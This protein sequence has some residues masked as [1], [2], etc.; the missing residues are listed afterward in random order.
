[1]N[2]TIVPI[3][4]TYKS[5]KDTERNLVAGEHEVRIKMYQ[6]RSRTYMGT[7]FSSSLENWNSKTG[8]PESTHPKFKALTARIN[9]LTE[10]ISFEIK[11][12]EKVGRIITPIEIKVM[13]TNRFKT[14]TP[15]DKPNKILAYIQH[16]IDYYNEVENPGYAGVF[17]ANKL[18]VKK[19]LKNNDKMFLAFT[20]ADHEALEKQLTGLSESTKSLYLR[21][22]YRVWNLAIADGFC[23]KD[24]HPR[25][26]IKFKPYKKIRTKKRSIKLDYWKRILKLKPA[27]DTR[28]YRSHLLMQFMYYSR[29]MN[30]NDMLKLKKEQF[31]NE[32][33]HYKRS[34]NKRSYDFQL[35][36]KAVKIIKAFEEYAEQSDAGYIFPFIYKE[37]DTALKI[38]ARIDSALKDLNED[39]KAMAEVVG[40][41]KQFTSNA[42]R[43]GFASHLNEANV[44]IKIIQEALGHETQAQTRVYL[45]D[46]DDSIIAS[47]INAALVA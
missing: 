27:K 32:G 15:V 42:L 28:I 5:V 6:N 7:G 26:H 2:I 1:M 34:K 41:K 3:L 17:Y 21:T 18:V 47:A 45:D 14:S 44:D 12:A 23:T 4:W 36:P 16:L 35:H 30:F 9:K 20:K 46:I 10:D 33:I 31:V 43:H 40:W 11:A 39:M 29:G 22:Y 25:K 8:Y 24:H 13:L 19:L 38:D 37:H